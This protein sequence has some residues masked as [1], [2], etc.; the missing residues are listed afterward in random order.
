M[1]VH[2]ETAIEDFWNTDPQK[3]PIHELLREAIP[4]KRWQQIDRFLH[5]SK[6]QL[7]QETQRESPFQKLEPLNKQLRQRFKQYWKAGTHLAVDKKIQRFIGRSKEIVNIPSKPTP[8]G[9]KIWVLA[10]TG[11]V[12]DWLYHAKG[13][14]QGPIDL[15]DFWTEDLGFSKTQA[16]VLDLVTQFG[17]AGDLQHI[18]W[19]D[20]LFTSAR[21]LRQLK[22]EG[23]GAAGTVR[24][25]KTARETIEETVGLK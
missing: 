10:N 8:E 6:P 17:I 15:D 18:I 13:D 4:L 24:T 7:P 20:N 2:A 16:V 22:K 25:A 5:I 3:G 23:F 19:L 14:S 9:F 21:L 12:L 11:Y 1:G